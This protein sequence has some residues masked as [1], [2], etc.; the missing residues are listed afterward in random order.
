MATKKTVLFIGRFQPFH[1]GHLD[2]LRKLAARY[3][4]VKLGIG[5]AQYKNTLENPLS[6]LERTRMIT[7]VLRDE[8]IKNVRIYLIPD[9]HENKRWVVHVR[10]IVGAF[11]EV[12]SGN[13]LV[14]KLFRE[15]KI[16]TKKIR[17]VQP[18]SGTGI[19]QLICKKK[20]IQGYVPLSVYSYLKKINA[21]ERICRLFLKSEHLNKK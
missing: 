4:V 11:D 12:Y 16:T 18:Y 21:F 17:L 3:D 19:R 10:A 8:T 6:A 15:R 7:S 14:L 13:G 1:H 20:D 9:V 5:S 2:V